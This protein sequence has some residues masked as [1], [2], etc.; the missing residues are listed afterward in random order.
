LEDGLALSTS[1]VGE[2]GLL[3]P[4]PVDPRNLSGGGGFLPGLPAV[5]HYLS[6]GVQK[7]FIAVTYSGGVGGVVV[8]LPDAQGN[9]VA[10]QDIKLGTKAHHAMSEGIVAGQFTRSGADDIAVASDGGSVVVLRGRGNGHFGRPIHVRLPSKQA[11]GGVMPDLIAAATIGGSPY[12]F[13]SDYSGRIRGSHD[14]GEVLVYKGNGAG[15][16][17]LKER[18]GGVARPEEIVVADFNHDG[19]LDLA[20]ANANEDDPSQNTPTNNSV[21]FFEGDGNGGFRFAQRVPVPLAPDQQALQGYARPIGLA[22]GDFHGDPNHLDVA[23]ADYN[24]APDGARG[25]IDVLRNESVD[26]GPIKFDVAPEF[27]DE[28]GSHLNTLAAVGLGDPLPGLAVTDAGGNSVFILHNRTTAGGPLTFGAPEPIAVGMAPT[29]VVAAKITDGDPSA[30]D[31]L[32]V[33][34]YGSDSV[35]VLQNRTHR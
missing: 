21:T 33:A 17:T 15:K 2:F 26:G 13:V 18:L 29:G 3:G 14:A 24:I 25:T 11:T 6:Q 35:T 32:I 28:F 31:D 4:F 16:F 34:N 12:L 30:N 8:F 10:S 9:F 5:G 1:A 22:V 23:V 27:T 7:P 20:V 19:T